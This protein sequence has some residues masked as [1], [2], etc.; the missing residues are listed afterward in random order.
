V[1]NN[2]I[3]VTKV[4]IVFAIIYALA[5]I[6]YYTVSK[7][8]LKYEDSE[9]SIKSLEHNANTGELVQ[10]NIVE[11]TFV[12]KD[13][14]INGLSFLVGTY[15]RKNIGSIEILVLEDASKKLL[16]QKEF[17]ISLFKDNTFFNVDIKDPI[18]DING[19]LLRIQIR[20]KSN[21]D[22]N[23]I[24]FW[25]NDSH[26]VDNQELF[27]NGQSREGTLCFTVSQLKKVSFKQDYITVILSFGLLI[28]SYGLYMI[29]CQ[30]KGKR[31]LGMNIII[32]VVKYRFLLIQLV[33]RDFK[34]KYRRSF[35]GILW[36]VLNPLLMM[37]VVSSVFSYVFRFNVDNFPVYLILGQ[38][39]FNFLS[40]STSIAMSS[41]LGSASLIKKVYMPKYIFAV[42]KVV[43]SLINFLIS[44]V[45]IGIVLLSNKIPLHSSIIYLPLIVFYMFIF[46][47]GLGLILSTVSVFFRDTL[48]LYSVLL[49]AW[50]YL[51]PIFYPVDSLSSGMRIFM[52][53]NP[54][55]Y[56]IEYFRNIILYGRMPTIQENLICFFIS[57][58]CLLLGGLVYKKHQDRFILYI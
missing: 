14:A 20:P 49:T 15:N 26:S 9:Y 50:S 29:W 39:L 41:I 8:Q 11:Q 25:Y 19:K 4:L 3:L 28:L 13:D 17:D 10:E 48:H 40:E 52:N 16:F 36:S 55:Y 45:A 27:V 42:G 6:F 37:I 58:A 31:S 32:A 7:N 57:V 53:F 22:G 46:C 35:L 43:F 38:T 23:A 1:K 34:T 2:K 30:I 54:M 18:T 33:S 5:A 21:V 56:Y 24:T 44:F 51:T 47:L 12:A